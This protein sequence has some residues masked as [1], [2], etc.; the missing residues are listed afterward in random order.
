[1]RQALLADRFKLSFHRETKEMPVYELVV[2]KNG[3]KLQTSTAGQAQIRM[4]RGTL[5]A[6]KTSLNLLANNLSQNVGRVVI[7]K[8]GLTGDFDIKLEWTPEDGERM[9]P[10]RDNGETPPSAPAPGLSIFT[11]LQEQLGL[12]LEARKG[13]VEILVIDRT[14]KPSEN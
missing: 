13:P 1:M 10:P 12:K 2:A 5:T 6:Q 7:D 3:P 14:E 8:T 9:G 11:A 4:G